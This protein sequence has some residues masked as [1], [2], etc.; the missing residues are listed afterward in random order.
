MDAAARFQQVNAGGG[1][2]KV[3]GGTAVPEPS[4]W[5]LMLLGFGGAGALIRRRRYAAA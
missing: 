3:K 5:A 1:S 2:D 4:T